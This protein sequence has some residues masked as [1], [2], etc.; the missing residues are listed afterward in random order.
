[1][2][3]I[4]NIS[5]NTVHIADDVIITPNNSIIIEEYQYNTLFKKLMSLERLNLIRVYKE[6]ETQELQ[7]NVD[8]IKVEGPDDL[9]KVEEEEKKI[10]EE[11][12]KIEEEDN[13]EVEVKSTKKS[14]RKSKK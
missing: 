1:M 10:E 3:R 11:V 2:R 13:K 4:L 7:A 14:T 9:E 5:K 12:K 8:D 6:Q